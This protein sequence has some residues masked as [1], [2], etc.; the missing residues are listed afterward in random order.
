MNYI[1]SNKPI[2]IIRILTKSAE[3]IATAD[4]FIYKRHYNIYT[5]I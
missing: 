3:A 5:M 2:N 1:I 4:F